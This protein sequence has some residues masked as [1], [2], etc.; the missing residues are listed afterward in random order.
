[1]RVPARTYGRRVGADSWRVSCMSRG[2][3][4]VSTIRSGYDEERT[5]VITRTSHARS[6]FTIVHR[7]LVAVIST[8]NVPLSSTRG[9]RR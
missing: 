4:A 6:A 8:P 2:N 3:I 7:V 9:A 5:T 1:M